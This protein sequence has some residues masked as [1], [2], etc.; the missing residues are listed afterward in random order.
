MTGLDMAVDA[1]RRLFRWSWKHSSSYWQ[2]EV[3]TL[4]FAIPRKSAQVGYSA[5]LALSALIIAAM[6][7]A[8]PMGAQG[9]AMLFAASHESGYGTEV[10]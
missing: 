3:L 5:K 10:A 9:M 8:P 7:L 6:L 1:R 4:D 2:W